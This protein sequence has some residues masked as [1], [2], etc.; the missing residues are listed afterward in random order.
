M[1]INPKYLLFKLNY[2]YFTFNIRNSCFKRVL[3]YFF[4]KKL[5]ERENLQSFPKFKGENIKIKVYRIF[6]DNA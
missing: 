5:I 4:D 1:T 6:Y 3:L 2:K